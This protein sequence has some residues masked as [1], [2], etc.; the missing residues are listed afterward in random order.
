MKLLPPSK[1][2]SMLSKKK[3][4]RKKKSKWDSK[5]LLNSSMNHNRWTM[6]KLRPFPCRNFTRGTWPRSWMSTARNSARLTWRKI[7]ISQPLLYRPL[8]RPITRTSFN[9]RILRICKAT[10]KMLSN[11][12]SLLSNNNSSHLNN[13]RLFLLLTWV[14]E[15][16]L[17]Q[18]CKT[19][20]LQK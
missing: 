3:K 17:L 4:D 8:S 1:C 7:S 20:M 18:A 19:K 11:S 16:H 12:N 14:E 9:N 13:S 10:S 15:S 2:K 6:K 5:W